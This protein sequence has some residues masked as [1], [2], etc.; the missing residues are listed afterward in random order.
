MMRYDTSN[1][2]FADGQ[3]G[4]NEPRDT[5]DVTRGSGE[6]PQSATVL[7]R[8]W[9]WAHQTDSYDWMDTHTISPSAEML[10]FDDTWSTAE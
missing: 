9:A 10:D 7:A 1:T 4:A 2:R 3:G 8:N 5:A 6:K